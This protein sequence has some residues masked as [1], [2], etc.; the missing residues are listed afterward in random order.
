[1]MAMVVALHHY[2]RVSRRVS[3]QAV[4]ELQ[5]LQSRRWQLAQQAQVLPAGAH[6]PSLD[7]SAD[8]KC[9]A[10]G[11]LLPARLGDKVFIKDDNWEYV[12]LPQALVERTGPGKHSPPVGHQEFHSTPRSWAS[13]L[14][15]FQQRQVRALTTD[16]SNLGVY[17]PHGSVKLDSVLGWSNPPKKSAQPFGL[18]SGQPVLVAAGGQVTIGDFPY[19]EVYSRQNNVTIGR[20]LALASTG[21]PVV[22]AFETELLGLINS[23]KPGGIVHELSEA[24]ESLDDKTHLF[25]D[26]GP[27]LTDGSNIDFSHYFSI[28]ASQSFSFI[29]IPWGEK[30]TDIVTHLRFWLHAPHPPDGDDERSK[31]LRRNIAAMSEELRGMSEQEQSYQFR[32]RHYAGGMALQPDPMWL[33][34]GA[35]IEAGLKDRFQALLPGLLADQK[36]IQNALDSGRTSIMA[37]V[38]GVMDGNL[39]TNQDL[40]IWMA[41]YGPGGYGNQTVPPPALSFIFPT[42]DLAVD[43]QGIYTEGE[44]C[45]AFLGGLLNKAKLEFATGKTPVPVFIGSKQAPGRMELQP[46]KPIPLNVWQEILL[47]PQPWA[48]QLDKMTRYD[49]RPFNELFAQRR[50]YDYMLWTVDQHHP[51]V[52]CDTVIWSLK[53][54]LDEIKPKKEAKEKELDK[55]YKELAEII[56]KT[57]PSSR[58]KEE[59]LAKRADRA[60]FR[61]NKG[62][63][64]AAFSAYGSSYALVYRLIRDWNKGDLSATWLPRW[65]LT[66][67]GHTGSSAIEPYLECRG[68]G[69]GVHM[70]GVLVVPAGRTLYYN[71]HIQ[72]AG[73]VWL[74]RGSTLVVRNLTLSNALGPDKDQSFNFFQPCGRVLLEEGANLIVHGDLTCEGSR[75]RGSVVVFSPPGKV[76]PIT[77]SILCE[78]KVTLPYGMISGMTMSDALCGMGSV[79]Q[80]INKYMAPVMNSVIPN[81][82]KIFGPFH[83]RRPF[84][85]EKCPEYDL[86]FIP[87][88][89]PWVTFPLLTDGEPHYDNKWVPL[90]RYASMFYSVFNNLAAAE[91]LY[92]HTDWWFGGLGTVLPVLPKADPTAFL[93]FFKPVQTPMPDVKDLIHNQLFQL[94]NTL[95]SDDP[96]PK[97]F[98]GA[99]VSAE[100]LPDKA[101]QPP[102]LRAMQ[103]NLTA[104]SAFLESETV[105]DTMRK[106]FGPVED[107]NNFLNRVV[108]WLQGL[109]GEL[110]EN[111]FG[112]EVSGAMIYARELSIGI[113][114]GQPLAEKPILASGL[115]VVVND[116][117]IH[118]AHTVGTLISISGSI[119]PSPGVT[120]RF[121]AYPLFSRA[122]L[123]RPEINPKVENSA[124]YKALPTRWLKRSFN[125]EYGPVCDVPTG[126]DCGV[127]GTFRTTVEGWER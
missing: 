93:P 30:V 81:V 69:L 58:E 32:L 110:L 55:A 104:R 116:I 15:V 68:Q 33:R 120:T 6:P 86:R 111:A 62:L 82:A 75:H 52:G 2:E 40:L 22:R 65:P 5:L 117:N 13:A 1:M 113:K 71:N 47:N 101:A 57:I 72:L 115:F 63:P 27:S 3:N 38:L 99:P 123:N 76:H 90:Y 53:Q 73:D 9:V 112:C 114:A 26:E 42:I 11:T 118:A 119:N 48:P 85:G 23:P 103:S 51:V 121:M 125:L 122:Y 43:R 41:E 88:P 46:G 79:G 37:S 80:T 21:A 25:D 70:N 78:G 14:D 16:L 89:I 7:L 31:E 60:G 67:Y 124:F 56:A 74:Q 50:F 61:D 83:W 39:S 18:A 87:T 54:K 64:G 19:G 66:F 108:L 10:N 77:S 24:A 106:F 96:R 4:A 36:I 29:T 8:L 17:A 91:N 102:D 107:F 45:L 35:P 98:L 109:D 126:L 59:A 44:I 100:A 97:A 94:T 92:L 28:R 34:S 105:P 12:G 20:G 49:G 95:R 127:P 84:F